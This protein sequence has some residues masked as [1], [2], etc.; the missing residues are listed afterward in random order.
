MADLHA[1]LVQE[2]LDV[3][4]RE[5]EP[6]IEHHRETDDLGAG[7]EPLERTGLGS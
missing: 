5:R 6:D 4:E 3:P 1:A 2:V 7:L